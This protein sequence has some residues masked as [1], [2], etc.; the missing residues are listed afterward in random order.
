MLA[1]LGVAVEIVPHL[2]K[3]HLDGAALRV[4]DAPPVIG[5]TLRY[6][7]IDN[8]WF[9]LMHELAHVGRHLDAGEDASFVHDHS[10]RGSEEPNGG[11]K[12]TEADEL[13]EEA[14]V[15][16]AAWDASEAARH[17]SGM[18]VMA[19]ASDLDIHPAIVAGRVRYKLDN[20]RLLSQ[21]VGSGHVRQQFEWGQGYL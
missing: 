19:L 20:Y 11:S 10:L 8:F 12:E 17:P 4:A 13:A 6:D 18:A 14:L 1:A 7:R 9:C 21:F 15:P 2:P 16:K 5:L 3:T